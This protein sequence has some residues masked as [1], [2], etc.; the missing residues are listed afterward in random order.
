MHDPLLGS[1]GYSEAIEELLKRG[2]VTLKCV[3]LMALQPFRSPRSTPASEI[4]A[5]ATAAPTITIL[6]TM[7]ARSNAIPRY[8]GNPPS[9]RALIANDLAVERAVLVPDKAWKRRGRLAPTRAPKPRAPIHPATAYWRQLS[10]STL[11]V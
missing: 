2:G 4:P 3:G 5:P 9:T 11:T 7:G 8:L 10:K 6:R 1:R